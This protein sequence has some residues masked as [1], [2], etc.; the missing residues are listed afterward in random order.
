MRK[1][2]FLCF[3]LSSTLG[4]A[5][6]GDGF[7]ADGTVWLAP[8]QGSQLQFQQVP[9]HLK[10]QVE[11]ILQPSQ[12]PADSQN[13]PAPVTPQQATPENKV[14]PTP[15]KE[16]VKAEE[17]TQPD[18]VEDQP[19]PSKTERILDK[20]INVIG[21]FQAP[22]QSK[23]LPQTTSK[24]D[25]KQKVRTV[26]TKDSGKKVVYYLD[27]EDAAAIKKQSDTSKKKKVRTV[28]TKDSGKKV[29]YDLVPEDAEA[30]KKASPTKVQI[31]DT[32]SSRS[33]LIDAFQN[34][35]LK[36]MTGIHDPEISDM[37]EKSLKIM[38]AKG[39]IGS[40]N[41]VISKTRELYDPDQTGTKAFGIVAMNSTTMPED[42][43]RKC[44]E[45][46][47]RNNHKM[48]MGPYDFFGASMVSNN[49]RSVCGAVFVKKN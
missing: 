9:D 7:S 3:S 4:Y 46:W 20:V 28:L 12:P 41:T 34:W 43:A 16:P 48:A 33:A 21:A 18:K 1:F 31:T 15:E 19:K 30:L 10:P 45:Y 27:P 38:L 44:V 35:G 11:A 6:G 23:P 40:L 37:L 14:N 5:S 24:Q 42:A 13:K 47:S 49:R 25:K 8:N 39:R 22:P 29:V 36:G 32:A 2:L 17:K 26:L